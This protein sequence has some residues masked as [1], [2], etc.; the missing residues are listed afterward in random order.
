MSEVQ[1]LKLWSV[2]EYLNGELKS[3]VRNEL[4]SGQL[5][6]M[7]GASN[8]HNILAGTLYSMLRSHL[9]KPCQVYMSDMK[10][11]V[12][13]NFYYPDIVVSCKPSEGKFYYLEEPTVIAEVLSPGTERQ[14][15]L[16]KRIAYQRLP[17]LQQ[18]LLLAQ[19]KL[20]LENYRLTV[21]GWELETCGEGDVVRLDS[22]GFE[23][24]IDDLYDDLLSAS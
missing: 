1:K 16:E 20:R 4:V 10:V 14:D 18:Y 15:R 19:D 13:D 2:D 21:D 12:A 17:S 3:D 11:R 24:A 5:Y 9:K 6:A 22:I 7:V 23:V 8:Y